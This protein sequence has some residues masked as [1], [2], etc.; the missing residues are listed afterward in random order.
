MEGKWLIYTIQ[1]I[2]YNCMP[3]SIQSHAD[4]CSTVLLSQC[5]HSIWEYITYND[6]STHIVYGEEYKVKKWSQGVCFVKGK[7]VWYETSS[8]ACFDFSLYAL[9]FTHS[10]FHITHDLFLLIW[11]KII[12]NEGSLWMSEGGRVF[13]EEITRS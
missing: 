7:P 10:F 1:C 13:Q 3:Y 6:T 12:H 9:N 11:H 8:W 4:Y 5:I 2:I